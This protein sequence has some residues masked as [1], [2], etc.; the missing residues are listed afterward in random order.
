MKKSKILYIALYLIG[1]VCLSGCND[2]ENAPT[3]DFTDSNFW[4]STDKAQRVINMGYSQMYSAARMWN[5]ECLSD[6][7]FQGRGNPDQRLIRNGLADPTIGIF[8]SEWKDLY[9]GIKTC[10]VFLDKID[11]VPDMDAAVKERMIAEVRYIRASI[12]FRLTC[13]YGD[14]PFFT[15]DIT[16]E[17]S[18][19][20]SRTPRA[21]VVQFIHDELDAIM[22]ILPTRDQQ[23]ESER[24][25]VTKGAVCALQARVYLYDSDWANVE[26]YCGYLINNQSEYGTY[27]LYSSYAGLFTQDGEYNS[28]IIM[29]CGYA[30]LLRTWGEMYDMA[31]LSLGARTNGRAPLQSLV[32]NYIMLNGKTIEEDAAYNENNP[33]VNR[34]PRLA[35]TVVYN[36]YDWSKNV[37]D[38]STGKYIYIKPGSTPDGGNKADEYVGGDAVSTSTGYYVRKYY[39][40]KHETSMASSINIITMRY[41]DILLMY[42]EAKL[43]QSGLTKDVWDMTIKPIRERAGFTVSAALD[44]PSGKTKEQMTKILRK[45]RRSEFALEGLRWFDIQRWKAGSEYLNGFVYGAKFANSSLDYI[46]LDNRKFSEARDYLWSVP[47]S[48]MDLNSNLKPNNPGYA[49]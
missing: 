20:I 34:D 23:K 3:N 31:P 28:E 38:G 46:R 4:T 40:A 36:E 27:S 19:T 24:G 49:N 44:F 9:G 29:D 47:L 14:I 11:L 6:N 37:N 1:I 39:D 48:Q 10:H 21:T 42:A 45:E 32:D 13:L 2:M 18:K 35:A 41:A 8:S 30:P 33:Y 43:E 15:K 25:K 12:F 26:K 16:L 22:P 17:E 5:D 7:M